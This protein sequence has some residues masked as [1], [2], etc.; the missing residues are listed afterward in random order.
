MKIPYELIS[1][2]IVAKLCV[3]RYRHQFSLNRNRIPSG[4]EYSVVHL[5]EQLKHPGFEYPEVV[6]L[7]MFSV[8]A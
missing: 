4:V 3:V 6:A 2:A 7:V 5:V 8:V 1:S